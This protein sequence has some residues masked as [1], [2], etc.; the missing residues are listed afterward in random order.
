MMPLLKVVVQVVVSEVV[1]DHGED[2]TTTMVLVL[3]PMAMVAHTLVAEGMGGQHGEEEQQ[4]EQQEEQEP[5]GT[6]PHNRA[7]G[8]LIVYLP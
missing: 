7:M 2:L 8:E 3:K 1:V 4:E 5:E 6:M